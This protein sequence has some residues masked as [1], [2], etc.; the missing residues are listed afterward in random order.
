MNEPVENLATGRGYYFNAPPHWRENTFDHVFR[1]GRAGGGFSTV[2]DLFRFARA[3]WAGKLVSMPSLKYL[4]R[5]HPPNNHGAGFEVVSTA[6]GKAVGHSSFFEGVRTR[7]SIFLDKG[8]VAVVLSNIEGGAPG[9]M[10]A[11]SN[12]IALAS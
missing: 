2:G 1:G 4:W 3:L 8:Y 9:L 12:Q 5:D 10:D 6:A 11:I 7:M